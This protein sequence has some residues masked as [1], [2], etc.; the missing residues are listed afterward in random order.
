MRRRFRSEANHILELGRRGV[1]DSLV[2]IDADGRENSVENFDV[3]HSFSKL[4]DSDVN[5]RVLAEFLAC[6]AL[7]TSSES[8]S[9]LLK[10]MS[11]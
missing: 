3:F 1:R 11:K 8:N 2:P 7:V 6:Q 5:F 9:H 4:F 10:M